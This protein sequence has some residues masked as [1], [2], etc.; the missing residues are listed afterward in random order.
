MRGGGTAQAGQSIGAG[1]II[2][3]SKYY[4]QIWN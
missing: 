3:T 1:L 2:D 4:N